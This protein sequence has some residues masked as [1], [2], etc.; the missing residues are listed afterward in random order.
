MCQSAR[1]PTATIQVNHD[2]EIKDM[3][4]TLVE[5]DLLNAQLME[6]ILRKLGHYQVTVTHDVET[7]LELARSYKTDFVVMDVSLN[8]C[9]LNGEPMDGISISR[10]LK[11]GPP[12]CH[13]PILLATAHAMRG[14]EERLLGESM[15]DGYISK[16]IVE[17]RTLTDKVT[18]MI[19]KANSNA[20]KGTV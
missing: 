10:L 13:V 7:V 2:A 11:T 18:D 4:V 3:H 15:A 1:S 19:E 17:P 20:Q 9:V 12:P 14:D 16:P 8:D 6:R 5:D